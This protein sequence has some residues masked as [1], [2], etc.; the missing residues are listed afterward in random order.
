MTS[1]VPPIARR[2]KNPTN[3]EDPQ[4]STP[5]TFQN[6]SLNGDTNTPEASSTPRTTDPANSVEP[7]VLSSQDRIQILDLHGENPLI[8]YR[9][10]FYTCHWASA[11]GTDLLFT[12]KR[13]DTNSSDSSHKP[14]T[15]IRSTRKYDLLSATS[16]RLVAKPAYL[17]PRIVPTP[18]APSSLSAAQPQAHF[19]SPSNNDTPTS[20][21]EASRIKNTAGKT[22]QDQ[23]SFLSRLAAIKEARGE[24]DV[25]PLDSNEYNQTGPRKRQRGGSQHRNGSDED[26]QRSSDD[27]DFYD[28]EITAKGAVQLAPET[29]PRDDMDGTALRELGGSIV[30]PEGIEF[31]HDDVDETLVLSL[32]SGATDLIGRNSPVLPVQASQETQP[33]YR[34][35]TVDASPSDH[36]GQATE[37]EPLVEQ[38]QIDEAAH[39]EKA[40][41]FVW[42]AEPKDAELRGGGSTAGEPLAGVDMEMEGTL[43][44][45]RSGLQHPY[46]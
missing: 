1:H 38:S 11:I 13:E 41:S 23:S 10:S 4:R 36:V 9:N 32:K 33:G 39:Q 2:R 31:L 17:V 34:E 25:V 44:Q 21:R 46:S 35:T 30:T 26:V 24:T 6:S 43:I 40:G 22:R 5:T 45:G 14:H 12:V 42:Q 15:P 28:G 19:T 18:G 27:V 7:E 37:G 29:T 20:I 3:T 16:L 8:T